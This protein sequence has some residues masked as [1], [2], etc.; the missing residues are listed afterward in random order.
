MS[1]TRETVEQELA[2]LRAENE[3]LKNRPAKGPKFSITPKG[4]IRV[5]G[6]GMMGLCLYQEQWT[7]LFNYLG[8]A[9]PDSLAN[10]ISENQSKLSVKPEGHVSIFAKEFAARAAAKAKGKK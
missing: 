9:V 5:P 6:I 3:A 7:R 1:H 10:F 2:R 8:V 4:T